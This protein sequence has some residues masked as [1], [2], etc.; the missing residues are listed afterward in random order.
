MEEV[1]MASYYNMRRDDKN[2][3]NDKNKGL[4]YVLGRGE[5]Y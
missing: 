1:K 4:I 3:K 2:D 5:L